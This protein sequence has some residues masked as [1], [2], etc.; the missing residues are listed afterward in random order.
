MLV[1][2]LWTPRPSTTIFD[3]TSESTSSDSD[4]S[5]S[6]GQ[7]GSTDDE[8]NNGISGLSVDGLGRHSPGKSLVSV[9]DGVHT[10]MDS[11]LGSELCAGVGSDCVVGG[12]SQEEVQGSMDSSRDGDSEQDECDLGDGCEGVEP[13]FAFGDQLVDLNAV[14][15]CDGESGFYLTDDDDVSTGGFC[16]GTEYVE[17]WLS[18][19]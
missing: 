5:S 8:L 7:A 19:W 12:D 3:E 13:E 16:F 4:Q 6:I 11:Y 1:S 15:E 2:L 10:Y 14:T 17:A 9:V 18:I